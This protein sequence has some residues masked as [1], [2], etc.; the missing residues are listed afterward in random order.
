MN[1]KFSLQLPD[2][3]NTNLELLSLYVKCCIMVLYIILEFFLFNL[4]DPLIWSSLSAISSNTVCLFL[5]KAANFFYI[6][7][8]L[9][10]YILWVQNVFG[11]VLIAYSSTSWTVLD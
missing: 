8:C 1:D 9:I 4:V 7:D 5:F 11:T 6:K 10:V 3:G 2:I